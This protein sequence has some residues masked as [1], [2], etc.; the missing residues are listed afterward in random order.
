MIGSTMTILMGM[1][2]GDHADV[3]I[4]SDRRATPN[5]I[6]RAAG[7]HARERVYKTLRLGPQVAIGFAGTVPLSNL[8]LAG[9]LNLPAP[10]MDDDI[11]TDLVDSEDSFNYTFDYVVDLLNEMA[12]AAIEWASPPPGIQASA[13]LAGADN[14]RPIL[15]TL[16]GATGWRVK[17]VFDGVPYSGP[18][19][20]VGGAG[21]EGFKKL[22]TAPDLDYI[23]SLKAAVTFCADRYDSVNHNYVIRRLGT[24]FVREEGRVRRQCFLPRL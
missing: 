1:Y 22:I 16:S 2:S 11:L 23:E 17:P 21:K 8:I 5:S 20:V 18:P 19:E 15:A 13:I 24:G 4:I 9:L 10:S 14:G 6:G 12:G 7:K 3:A